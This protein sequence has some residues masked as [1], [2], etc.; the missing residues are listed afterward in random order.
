MLK[1]FDHCISLSSCAEQFFNEIGV[2]NKYIPNIISDELNSLID[3][4]PIKDKEIDV[5]WVGRLCKAKGVERLLWVLKNLQKKNANRT[6]KVKIIGVWYNDFGSDD[7]F[8]LIKNHFAS[9]VKSMC[10]S[11]KLDITMQEEYDSAKIYGYM[12]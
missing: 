3:E 7:K 12:K 1:Y 5:L 9:E 2:H 8:K 11:G 10:E 4:P 6:L